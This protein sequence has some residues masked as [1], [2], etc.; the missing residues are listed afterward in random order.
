[1]RPWFGSRAWRSSPAVLTHG[2]AEW[3]R[4]GVFVA[5]CDGGGGGGGGE[6]WQAGR[7]SWRYGD[8][9]VVVEV[10]PTASRTSARLL[11]TTGDVDMGGVQVMGP[12]DTWDAAEADALARVGRVG[13]G[14]GII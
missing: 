11:L 3:I 7:V 8:D 6:A 4:P 10:M 1:M 5:V 13:R 12:F 9:A 14:G 2:W